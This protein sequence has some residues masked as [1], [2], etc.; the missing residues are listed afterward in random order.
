[1]PIQNYEVLDFIADE[2]KDV[3]SIKTFCDTN[4]D[5]ENITIYL[6]ADERLP[7]ESWENYPVVVIAPLPRDT[8]EA[9]S[10][11]EYSFMATVLIEGS[12]K[13]II[14]GNI[15]KYDGIYK[16]EEMT[17]LILDLLENSFSSKTNVEALDIR[18][19]QA[20]IINFP[21]VEADIIVKFSVGHAIGSDCELLR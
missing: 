16:I 7:P 14:D 20:P 12:E 17:T 10:Q 3:P 1:M 8:G 9:N 11:S 15:V 4:F 21:I 6:G 5:K 13:P 19:I 18:Y 2:I